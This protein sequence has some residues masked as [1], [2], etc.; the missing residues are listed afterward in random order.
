MIN[1][2]KIK[3]DILWLLEGKT[4]GYFEKIDFSIKIK[5][6][7]KFYHRHIGD[8]GVG[9]YALLS[10]VLTS[11][12]KIFNVTKRLEGK[13][14]F[15]GTL[16]KEVYEVINLVALFCSPSSGEVRD[17]PLSAQEP[18]TSGY[19]EKLEF[20]FKIETRKILPQAYV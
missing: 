16:K 10:R 1:G 14:I 18:R 17:K 4:T 8:I 15:Q 2:S 20:S 6:W 7:L 19:L 3:T 13:A 9:V 12:D 11:E 5:T